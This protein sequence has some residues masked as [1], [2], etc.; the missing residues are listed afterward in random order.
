MARRLSTRKRPSRET[1]Q[2]KE[3][4]LIEGGVFDRPTLLSLCRMMSRG[5]FNSLDY[6]I[7]T[8]K[9]AN[10]F[11]A[12]TKEGYLA[13]K[14]Y[15]IETSTF[16]HMGGYIRDDRRF[17]HIR[18]GKKSI[19]FAWAKKEFKNLTICEE[20]GVHAPK[21][22]I[23]ERNILVMEF[24]GEEGIPYSTMNL[25]GSEHPKE[26][27]ESILTDIKKLYNAG[28]VHADISEFNIMAGDVPYLIDVGQGLLLDHPMA[29][30]FLIRDVR[31]ILNYFRRGYGI[32]KDEE[33]VLRW[34]KGRS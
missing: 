2:I 10:V 22:I 32:E 20:A 21:P 23:C 28:L 30:E 3:R 12:T 8:G 13:V 14:I 34:I 27:L 5:I 7:A 18:G 26:D 11:R 6:P 24:L 16:K 29:E 15:R 17:Q 33:E 19:V 9:E 31:N 4:R 25:V 1:K